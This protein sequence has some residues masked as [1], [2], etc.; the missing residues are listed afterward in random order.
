[1]LL[2][3]SSVIDAELALEEIGLLC[4]MAIEDSAVCI[5][6]KKSDLNYYIREI[7]RKLLILRKIKEEG[8]VGE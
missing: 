2:R 7:E 5:R 1:M 8:G 6:W 4:E 3:E